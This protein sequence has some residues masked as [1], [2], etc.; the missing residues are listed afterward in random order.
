M[1][2]RTMSVAPG[3]SSDGGAQ[4][5]FGIEQEV[6]GDDHAVARFEAAPDL[7]TAGGTRPERDF[8]RLVLAVPLVEKHESALA[9]GDDGALGD[10]QGGGGSALDEDVR[11]HVRLQE[12]PRVVHLDA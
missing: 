6:G 1:M 11:E 4:A 5:G 3:G 8:A 10:G 12:A 9:G 7:V 2:R